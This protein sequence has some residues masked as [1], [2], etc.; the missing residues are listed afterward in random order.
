[1][2][3]AYRTALI[4]TFISRVDVFD[5][6]NARLEIYCYANEG[7][8]NCPLDKREMR[9]SKEQLAQHCRLNPNRAR[10]LYPQKKWSPYGRC[11]YRSKPDSCQ[12]LVQY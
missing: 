1:M 8:I 4:D 9:S 11:N 5:G 10:L 2:T 3:S 6:D 12:I 7:K